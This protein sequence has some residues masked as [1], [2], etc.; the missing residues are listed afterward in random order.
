MIYSKLN[1][2]KGLSPNIIIHHDNHYFKVSNKKK[3]LLGIKQ[4]RL[5]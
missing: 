4:P 3:K 5:E 2:D 1:F